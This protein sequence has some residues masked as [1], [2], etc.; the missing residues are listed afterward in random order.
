VTF[1]VAG[2]V[3]TAIAVLAIVLAK[4]P[5]DELAHPPD[6]QP[7]ADEASEAIEVAPARELVGAAA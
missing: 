1:A 6:I 7:G 4:M 3:P 2:L 5:K